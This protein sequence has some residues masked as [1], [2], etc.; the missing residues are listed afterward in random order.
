MNCKIR[1]GIY[2]VAFLDSVISAIVGGLK[3]RSG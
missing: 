3:I 1:F 2:L